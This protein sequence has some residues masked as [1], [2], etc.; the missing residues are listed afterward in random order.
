MSNFLDRCLKISTNTYY[1]CS[2]FRGFPTLEF[3][4]RF[5]TFDIHLIYA[6]LN[7]VL[8]DN[9]LVLYKIRKNLFLS[10]STRHIVAGRRFGDIRFK[11]LLE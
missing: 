8:S 1:V 11:R 10:P 9:R 5:P 7:I 4:S 3:T 2:K 6:L